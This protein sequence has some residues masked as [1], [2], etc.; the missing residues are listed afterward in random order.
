MIPAALAAIRSGQVVG[1]PTDT[2]YGIGVDPSDAAAVDLL[3]AMKGRRPDHPLG[4]L[5]AT[6]DQVREV[7]DVSDLGDELARRHWPGPLTLVLTSRSTMADGIGDH[8][9]NTIGV[10]VPDHPVAIE[11]L[12]ATGPLAV[13]SANVSGGPETH[14][15]GEARK[16]FGDRVA[17]YLPG[18]CPGGT[19]STVADVTGTRPVIIRSGP[20]RL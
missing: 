10:R 17:V 13:T 19:A 4:L 12:N 7:A 6:L 11:F 9:R 8:T 14:D 3:F 1:L 18:V 5:V 15:D 20:V 16:V 2:V